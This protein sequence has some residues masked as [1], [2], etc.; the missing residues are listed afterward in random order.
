MNILATTN[1]RKITSIILQSKL[2]IQ[3]R[4]CLFMKTDLNNRSTS[5]FLLQTLLR[6]HTPEKIPSLG[7]EVTVDSP[8]DHANLSRACD[9]VG[10][11]VT[12]I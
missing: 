4:L 7:S 8:Q 11:H 10:C 1:I 2:Q 5:G 9:A 12:H 3:Y 6:L